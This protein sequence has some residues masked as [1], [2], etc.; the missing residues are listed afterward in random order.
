MQ[1]RR[2]SSPAMSC[3]AS[4]EVGVGL[5]DARGGIS[6]FHYLVPR[7]QVCGPGHD[8]Y[9][10][11]ANCHLDQR[12]AGILA[13][14]ELPG[15]GKEYAEAENLQRVLPANNGWLQDRRFEDG[16]V[17]RYE[18]HRYRRQR[19]KMRK[20]QHVKIGLV[21]RIHPFTQP[22]GYETAERLDVPGQRDR[23]GEH[24][25]ANRN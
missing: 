17:A 15:K 22:V 7:Y 11:E 4:R 10:G 24:Q 1:P 19:E 16:P 18:T 5:F 13:D 25:I 9:P 14:D 2:E 20:A 23:E 6:P 8:Q 21:D 12:A 3:L